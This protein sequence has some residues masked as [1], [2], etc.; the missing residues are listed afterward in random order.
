MWQLTD[1]SFYFL[2][3]EFFE[4]YPH[5]E[6]SEIEAKRGRPYAF[7]LIDLGDGSTLESYINRRWLCTCPTCLRREAGFFSGYVTP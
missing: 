4:R 3:D 6:F 1:G 7:C 5:E 2:S